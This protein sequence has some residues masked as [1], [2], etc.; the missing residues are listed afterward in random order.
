[1]G[2][3]KLLND[4]ITPTAN[5]INEIATRNY[6]MNNIVQEN[7]G[8]GKRESLETVINQNQNSDQNSMQHND[9]TNTDQCRRSQF[10]PAQQFR[11]SSHSYTLH[12]KPPS[13]N[14][15]NAFS[16]LDFDGRIQRHDLRGACRA[17][18]AVLRDQ[19]TRDR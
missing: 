9:R 13:P 8:S 17:M 12:P 6:N 19:S 2:T 10:I 14:N 7:C 4:G 1:M 5:K 15:G 16:T 18:D 3:Q 11:D